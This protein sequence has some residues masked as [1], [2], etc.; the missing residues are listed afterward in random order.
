MQTSI[1]EI[2]YPNKRK[3]ML[4][5]SN[6]RPYQNDRHVDRGKDFQMYLLDSLISI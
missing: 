2:H 4:I 3:A 1:T 6:M 5:F